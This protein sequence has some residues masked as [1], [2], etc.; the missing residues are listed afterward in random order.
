M[1]KIVTII[2]LVFLCTSCLVH[3]G[4]WLGDQCRPKKAN[5]RIL[6]TPFR[7]TDKLSFESVYLSDRKHFGIGFYPD[8]RMMYFVSKGNEEL[9]DQDIVGIDWNSAKYI[10]YWRVEKN[11]IKIEYFVCGDFG[12]YREK[13]G[14][15]KGDTVLFERYC[16]SSPFKSEK[17][18][19]KY[20]LSD[21]SLE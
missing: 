11:E 19:S 13:Q 12:T 6:K 1:R 10:G 17:C 4:Q 18:F 9:R 21:I 8:G 14:I 15:I 2:C 16:S 20:V 5:F 7:E 3:K